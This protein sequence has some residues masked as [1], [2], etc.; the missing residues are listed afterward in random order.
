MDDQNTGTETPQGEQAAPTM[1]T[2]QA[3]QGKRPR[4]KSNEQLLVDGWSKLSTGDLKSLVNELWN[5]LGEKT[6]LV[7]KELNRRKILTPGSAMWS[8]QN[9]RTY[10]EKN[11]DVKKKRRAKPKPTTKAEPT[12]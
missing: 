2:P 1:E 12:K 7:W 3:P 6:S 5:E 10:L 4:K 8:Y 9:L 11:P